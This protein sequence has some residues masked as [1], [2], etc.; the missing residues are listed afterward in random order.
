MRWADVEG[1][2]RLAGREPLQA[3]HKHLEHEA[4][5]RLEMRRDI[6]EA[7]DLLILRRQVHDRVGDEVSDRE[8]AFDG[9]RCEVADRDADLLGTRLRAQARNHRLGKVDSV[10]SYAALRER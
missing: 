6:L 7:R 5:T 4:T 3:G 10:H 2:E 8:R 1:P 9:R